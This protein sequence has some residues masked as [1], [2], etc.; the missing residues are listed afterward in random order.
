MALE[1]GIS[2]HAPL[3]GRD[4]CTIPH[5]RGIF[6][7]SIHAPLAGRDLRHHD[8]QAAHGI[9]IHAPLAG[10]DEGDYKDHFAAE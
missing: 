8:A 2:I 6:K 5:S 10:R 9:S 3:A 4:V 1:A 7:I